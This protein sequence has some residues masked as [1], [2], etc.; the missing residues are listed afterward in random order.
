MTGIQAHFHLDW[1]GF[2]L[3][4]NLE[5]PARGVTALFGPS[6]CGKTTLLRCIAGLE[7]AP[8]GHLRINGDVW[9]SDKHWL[10][11]H[12]R[13]LGYVFQ[14][15][16][17][18]PH[19]TVMGNLRYGMRRIS[20]AQQ[21][22]LEQAVDLLGIAHLLE[23]KP[24][25]LSGG[26]RQRVAIARALLTSPRL[27]LMDEPLAA[28]DLARKNE[29]MP[30]LERLHGELDIPVIYVTHA[31]DEVARLADH[32][33]VME[34]GRAIASGPLTET[35]A[36]LDLPIR[37]GEDA[38]VVLDAVVAERDAAWHLARVTFA[39][40]SLWVRDGGQAIGAAV[41]IRILARDVS[42]ALAHVTGTSIQNCLSATVGEMANDSHPALSLTRLNI[43]PSPLLAR[44]TRRSAVELGL[45]PGKPVWVQIKAVAL[46]G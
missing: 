42:I 9:Q 4:V 39:G 45:A 10:P 31:P 15:A 11:T 7:R 40:G 5:L 32:I 8:Q 33:V 14:E 30:Y 27:L 22:S 37:L 3:D 19:L 13:P 16:S 46:I 28:L 41:R 2:T 29:F 18:F 17:L 24:A 25:G 21:V 43:G 20:Q 6:G 35:L 1:P 23:R 44:L 12:K 34:A 26:E 36:R 38:G